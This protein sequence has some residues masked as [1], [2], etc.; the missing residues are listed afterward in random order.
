VIIEDTLRVA[1]GLFPG[2]DDEALVRSIAQQY[3]RDSGAKDEGIFHQDSASLT[4]A[5]Q[6]GK[7][8][9]T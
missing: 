3:Q 1:H 6:G 2:S 7:I 5:E 4:S 9:G 8:K